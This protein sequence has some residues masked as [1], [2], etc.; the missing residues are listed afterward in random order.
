MPF[1]LESLQQMQGFFWVLVRVSI[2]LFLL[3]LFGAKGIPIMW[4]AGLSM[5]LAIILTPVVPSPEGFPETTSEVI[6]GLISEVIMGLILGLGVKMLFS[7]VQIAGQFMAFQMGFA[8]ARAVDPMTGIQ[9]TALSQFL[10]LFT[11][12]IF[13]SVDGHHLFIR[14]LATSFYVVPPNTLRFDPSLAG[15]LIKISSQMFLLALKIAAPIMIALF[16][17]NLCLGIVA[18]TVPQVNI[19][20]VGFPINICLGLIF[21]GMVLRNLSP[22]L[23]DLTKMI[24]E[25]LMRMIHLM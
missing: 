15:V 6:V 9:S 13:F 2:I 11:I 8:M 18:R 10:Y 4:K 16:L 21:F 7:V 20:M 24:G 23:I 22:F 12:L 1:P 25:A 17:S 19:L 14:S 5:A 3:P